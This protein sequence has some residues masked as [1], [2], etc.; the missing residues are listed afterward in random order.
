MEARSI[1]VTPHIVV[2]FVASVIVAAAPVAAQSSLSLSDAVARTLAHNPEA[3]AVEVAERESTERATQARAGYFPRVRVDES[4]HRGNQP[5]FV[6]SS[7]LAQRQLAPSDFA[8]EALTHPPAIDNFRTTLSVEQALFDRHRTARVRAAAIDRDM[9]ATRRQL[10]ELDL[11]AAV[12]DAFGAVLVAEA[13]V[14]S[15]SAAVDAARVDRQLAGNRRDLGRATEADVLQLDVYLARAR[16][17]QAQATA[18]ERIARVRLNQLMGE[19]LSTQFSLDPAPPPLAMDLAEIARL[20]AYAVSHRPEVA[21]ALHAE[22][23]ASTAV[24][25]ARAAFFPQVSAQGTWE[26]NGDDWRARSASWTVG[27]AIRVNVFDGF[28][29]R[30]R[31]AETRAQARRRALDRDNA[32][33][34]IRLEVH[35]ALAR[36]E[37]ARARAAVG[38]A[39]VD[40][41]RESR[42]II[43][44]RYDTGLADLALLLRSADAVQHAEAQQVAA[45][46]SVL[47]ATAHLQ[48]ALGR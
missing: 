24:T 18:D 40:Q 14:R 27:A 46:V 21:L 33:A 35:V 5:A 34:Q 28:G 7:R 42:R 30:A 8:L 15:A 19:P 17:R 45:Q 3:K 2:A 26:L 44:D 47:T 48:R 41:A 38:R 10:V 4:W 20:E 31:L 1:V 11:T 25:A 29:D 12:T 9:A 37:A 32:E 36:L 6:F 16:E 13:S 22:R 43:R 39:A 23:L